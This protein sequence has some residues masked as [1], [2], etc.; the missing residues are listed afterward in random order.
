VRRAAIIGPGL[1]FTDKNNGF[2]FYPPQTLQ[3]FA[4]MDSL[5]RL[6]LAHK[7]DLRVTIFD[8]SSQTLDHVS[9]AIRRARLRQPYFIQLMLDQR[10]LWNP[11][12]V[13]Y[14]R[15]FGSEVGVPAD[16]IPVPPQVQNVE[17]RAVR[18]AP[19]IVQS[20]E[21][22]PLDVVLQHLEQ[23]AIEQYDL[24]VATNIFIYYDAFD[25]GLSLLNL[26][27][28]L[29]PGGVFLSNDLLEECPGV[30][31]RPV[32]DLAVTYS[33]RLNDGDRIEVYAKRASA[34]R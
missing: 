6:G 8:I 31:L 29:A 4:L 3:P 7:T 19:E 30:T 9:R 28:M 17:T 22:R 12:A 5:L 27:S 11:D 34:R 2:D 25:H 21:P 32:D 15:R 33:G 1:D 14:W 20:L 16:P 26:D 10:Q 23:P 18:I 13:E 24:I